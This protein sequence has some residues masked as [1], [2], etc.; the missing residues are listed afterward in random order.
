MKE[1]I[2]RLTILIFILIAS[3][4]ALPR[5]VVSQSV[6]ITPFAPTRDSAHGS[7]I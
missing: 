4:L 5:F 7:F 3:S 1:S 6:E 2:F